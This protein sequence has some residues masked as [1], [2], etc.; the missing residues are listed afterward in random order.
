MFLLQTK[1]LPE[2]AAKLEE[3]L[4]ES[5][6]QLVQP[7]GGRMVTVE[8]KNYPELE[9]IRIRLD[10][11]TAGD[12]LPARPFPVD[13]AEPALHA[14]RFEII[15]RPVRVQGAAVHLECRA[16]EVKIGQ[17]R[18]ASGNLVLLLQD[19]GDG[20]VEAAISLSDLEKLVRAGAGVVTREH[21]VILED[22]R[23][24]L[25][26]LSARSLAA[27]V[28]V[29]ARKLFLNAAVEVKGRVEIDDQM[30]AH[31]SGLDCSGEGTL[32]TLACGFI[33]PHL[34][35]LEGRSFSL[36]ALPLGEVQLR[37]VRLSIDDHL[38]VRA[39]FGHSS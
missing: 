19:A 33:G 7:A 17:A 32:G 10:D 25:Q 35:R 3:V 5:L 12:Q 1:S 8:D 27:K 4:E 37:E 20:T 39:E 22:V 16:Q 23:I 13:P 26:A 6:R 28:C 11:A 18:D 24:Q 2:N 36:L 34:Q 38:R 21:G 9:A 31:L 14:A 15:G 29:R 30:M